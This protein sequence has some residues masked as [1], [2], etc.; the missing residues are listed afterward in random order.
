MSHSKAR[1]TRRVWLPAAFFGLFGLVLCARLVQLQVLEHERYAAEAKAGLAGNQTIYARRGAILDRNGGVLATSVST[2]DVYVNTRVW[3]DGT[4]AL[5]SSE[6]LATH[7]NVDAVRLREHVRTSTG[8]EIPLMRDVDFEVGMELMRLRLPGVSFLPNTDRIYPEGDLA[9]SI[10]GLT[11]LEKA[12]LAG[13]ESR[14]NDVLQGIPGRVIYERDTTGDPIPYG[15]YV[16]TEPRPG[17]TVVLTIDRFIQ[18]L[19]EERLAN[20]IQEHRAKSGSIIVMNPNTGEILALATWPPLQYSTLDL[21]DPAS[22]ALLRNPAVTDM[23]EPGSVMK[24]VTA[25]AAIDGGAVSPGTE[26]FDG[27]IADVYGVEI[28]NWDDRSY[29]TQTMTGVLQH[30]INTGAIFMMQALEAKSPGAFQRYL[31]AFG[32]DG[33]TGS[34]LEGE[35]EGIVRRPT[36][37]N[38]S[39]VDLAT[40][41]F[42][43]A[44]SVTPI[45][46]ISAIAACING[47]NLIQPHLLK[48]RIAPDG[49]RRDVAPRVVGR[50]ISSE[51]SATIRQMLHDVV[52]GEG[53]Y[54][55]GNPRLYS[56]GGKSGTANV[57][58]TNGYDDTQIASFVGF[59]PLDAPE[60]LVLVKLDENADGLTGTAA[61][62]PVFA[63]LADDA[64]RY[65]NIRPDKGA[66]VSN[67]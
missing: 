6:A 41:S 7:L 45:Q 51:T 30:S 65:L 27:G 11:G 5:E 49:T 23:Y 50:A 13:I 67:R 4:A 35:A 24:V 32:F 14:Y 12:G 1:P 16:A 36:D 62:A 46:M 48:A 19:A 15:Q 57:P 18:R 40:Q 54:H 56:A 9:A 10:L 61:A 63:A 22:N 42:G 52:A 34:D 39:P 2:W 38:W 3:K 44:I 47:G 43:Q 53:V 29:G 60:I 55:P 20:A 64:L 66:Y 21:N 8:V 17:D 37:P 28:K 33:A 59:A 58:V 31:D 26:Y 25:A